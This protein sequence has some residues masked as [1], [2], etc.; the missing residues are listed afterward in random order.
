LLVALFAL[1]DVAIA[2]VVTAG[3]V[4]G[5]LGGTAERSGKE[6][7]FFAGGGNFLLVA[8]FALVDEA[9]A[10]VMAGR[11]VQGLTIGAAFERATHKFF[12]DT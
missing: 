6:A 3:S 9:I 8:L 4:E 2:A 12:A 11:G 10:A 7:L 5:A 1:V